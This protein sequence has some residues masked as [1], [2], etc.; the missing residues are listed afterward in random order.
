MSIY[1][2]IYND[3]KGTP[4]FRILIKYFF[5]IIHIYIIIHRQISS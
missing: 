1:I 4:S 2:Y 5:N 3:G